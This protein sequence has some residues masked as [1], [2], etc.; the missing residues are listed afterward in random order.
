M[1]QHTGIFNDPVD[2]ADAPEHVA[3]QQQNNLESAPRWID[4]SAER[5]QSLIHTMAEYT[6]D[7]NNRMLAEEKRIRK[8]NRDLYNNVITELNDLVTERDNYMKY[9]RV[10]KEIKDFLCKSI[11]QSAHESSQSFVLHSCHLSIQKRSLARSI[12]GFLT[13]LCNPRSER[14]SRPSPRSVAR[15]YD[16]D[17]EVSDV[18]ERDFDRDEMIFGSL[19]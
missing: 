4:Y 7:R 2:M 11:E 3:S 8:I 16:S 6:V 17:L 14:T 18:D 13:P 9:E 5:F 1:M 15:A 19:T 12:Y 10:V